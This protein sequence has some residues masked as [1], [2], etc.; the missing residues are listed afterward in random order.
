MALSDRADT[1]PRFWRVDRVTLPFDGIGPVAVAG[2]Q[3]G[4]GTGHNGWAHPP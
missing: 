1:K 2:R 4:A 3:A